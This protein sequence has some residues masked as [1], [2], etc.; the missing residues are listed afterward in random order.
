MKKVSLV[1]IF[2]IIKVEILP[3]ILPRSQG[4]LRLQDGGWAPDASH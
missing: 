4:L 2:N 3:F 1:G